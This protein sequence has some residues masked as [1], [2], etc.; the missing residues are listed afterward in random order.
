MR[1]GLRVKMR[2]RCE[3]PMSRDIGTSHGVIDDSPGD[4][5]QK[6]A[7]LCDRPRES[8][9]RSARLSGKAGTEDSHENETNR[10]DK[11]DIPPE[12]V[13]PSRKAGFAIKR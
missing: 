12:V 2:R 5:S 11:R 6:V 10:S 3:K 1:F 8:E 13:A 9:L 4:T 7:D